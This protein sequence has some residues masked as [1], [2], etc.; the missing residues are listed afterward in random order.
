MFAPA[1]AMLICEFGP[2]DVSVSQLPE[3]RVMMS[4]VAQTLSD[5]DVQNLAAYYAGLSCRAPVRAASAGTSLLQ[6]ESP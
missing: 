4:P 1:P 5:A 3:L 2:K 6:C